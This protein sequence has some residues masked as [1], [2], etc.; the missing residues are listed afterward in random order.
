L[1]D[2][3]LA[4]RA[5]YGAAKRGRSASF[6]QTQCGLAAD[7]FRPLDESVELQHVVRYTKKIAATGEVA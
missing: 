2:A 6:V 3:Y 5:S 1:S 7:E 4:L